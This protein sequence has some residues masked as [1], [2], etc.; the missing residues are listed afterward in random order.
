MSWEDV[1]FVSGGKET[2][3]QVKKSS[4]GIWRT[5]Q[6][7]PES[8]SG[9]ITCNPGLELPPRQSSYLTTPHP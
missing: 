3:R 6:S 4:N 9:R 1:L 7:D 5:C 8:S 2:V